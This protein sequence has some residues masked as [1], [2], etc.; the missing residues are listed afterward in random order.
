V[1]EFVVT[2]SRSGSELNGRYSFEIMDGRG[3]AVDGTQ[4]EFV[5]ATGEDQTGRQ[6]WQRLSRLHGLAQRSA[7]KSDQAVS[8]LLSSLEQIR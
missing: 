5:G 4:A 2:V 1:G 6:N 7:L 3:R 8:E